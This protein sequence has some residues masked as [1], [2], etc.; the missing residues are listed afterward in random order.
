MGSEDFSRDDSSSQPAW[1]T[2]SSPSTEIVERIAARAEVS[3]D[4][5][6][7]LYEAIDPEALNA[8]FAPRTNGS[9]RT[10][11]QVTF[12]YAGYTVTVTSDRR[13]VRI[14]IE[15]LDEHRE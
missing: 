10:G 9:D 5:L 15:P 7:P 14:D 1:H 11:G 2:E 4:D 13:A 3:S 6:E 12:T 8:L